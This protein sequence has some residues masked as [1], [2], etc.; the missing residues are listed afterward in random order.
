MGEKIVCAHGKIKCILEEC[1]VYVHC[2]YN[3]IIQSEGY[4]HTYNWTRTFFEWA[5]AKMAR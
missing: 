1:T 4:A 3:E 5:C 2:G